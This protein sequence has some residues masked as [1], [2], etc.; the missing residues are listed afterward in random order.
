[1]KYSSLSDTFFF[2]SGIDFPFDFPLD[3][4]FVTKA[5]RACMGMWLP[6]CAY[7]VVKVFG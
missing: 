7:F 2:V 1:L 4:S 6:V 3:F 5:Y